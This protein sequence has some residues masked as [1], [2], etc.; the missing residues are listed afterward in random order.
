LLG[1]LAPHGVELSSVYAALG[2][3]LGIEG[4]A[5][6]EDGRRDDEGRVLSAV[7]E[8]ASREPPGTLLS[9][10]AVRA[11]VPIEKARFDRAALRLSEAGKIVLHHHDFPASLSPAERAELVEDSRGTHYIGV[12][13]RRSS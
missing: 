4:A 12:A 5:P 13:L 6:I 1:K 7:R 10:R 2:R 9:V 3:A 8:L 11:T